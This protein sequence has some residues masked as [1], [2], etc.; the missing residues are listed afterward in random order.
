MEQIRAR[1]M[2]CKELCVPE[3]VLSWKV[4]WARGRN[5]DSGF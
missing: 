5:K 2:T 4:Q 3:G 1:L